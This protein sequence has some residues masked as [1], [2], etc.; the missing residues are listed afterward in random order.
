M[1]PYPSG[2]GLHV[3]H[4]L[5]YIGT[6][7][8]AR[9][10]RMRGF[11]VLHPMGF[12]AFGLPAEQFAVEH[13][14]HPRATTEANI[15]NMVRQLKRLGLSYDWD[16]RLATTDVGYYKWTQ[17]IF[18]Q[19]YNS[20]VDPAEGK[21]RPIDD[22][23]QKLESGELAV[24]LGN[25]LV[26]VAGSGAMSVLGGAPGGT[27]HWYELGPAEQEQV[28]AG[29]RLAY[30]AEVVVNWCPALGTVLANE[31]VTSDGR[32]DRGNHPVYKRPL[33]QWML[34]ITAYADRLAEELDLVDWPG[35]IRLMQRNWIGRSEGARRLPDRRHRRSDPACSP[36]AGH[37][38]RRYHMVLSPNTRS[39]SRSPPPTSFRRSRG[40]RTKSEPLEVARM[41]QAKTGVFTGAHAVNPVNRERIPIWIADYVLRGVAPAPSR[42]CR[43]TMSATSTWPCRSACRFARW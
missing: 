15:A 38:V 3:G 17:W 7:I 21:A 28:L 14:V 36:R 24:G 26:S 33:R 27:R 12:D 34:R 29:Q 43:H 30:L 5:G 1:F 6:D 31:E 42:P 4:P 23:I 11:N 2:V 40:I 16:R 18:L 37:A 39:S 22:L 19:L 41:A 10:K 25:A 35:P 9:D 8:V 13:G 20:Y 32:S